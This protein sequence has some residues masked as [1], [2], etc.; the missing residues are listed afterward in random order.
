MS[1]RCCICQFKKCL[2][3]RRIYHLDNQQQQQICSNI[4]KVKKNSAC[5]KN[6]LAAKTLA[7]GE[8]LEECYMIRLILLEIYNKESNS[9][10][11]PIHCYTDNKFLLESVYSTKT[12][13][14]KRLKVDVCIIQEMFDKKEIESI[15]QCSSEK[16]LADCLTKASASCTKLISVL[17]EESGM[18]KTT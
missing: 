2:I 17:H 12:L 1:L 3:K 8:A 14:V 10:Q 15:N 18:L 6:T 4:Q 7:L 13:K 9:E 5:C 11:F 16:Q